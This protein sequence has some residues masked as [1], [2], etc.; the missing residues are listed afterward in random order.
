[1]MT[2]EKALVLAQQEA[3]DI[4]LSAQKESDLDA[5]LR[6]D[7]HYDLSVLKTYMEKSRETDDHLH[8]KANLMM[9]S[10]LLTNHIRKMF[11]YEKILNVEQLENFKQIVDVFQPFLDGNVKIYNKDDKKQKSDA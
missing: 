1:M 11:I 8:V 3:F 4:Y 7:L 6:T 9:G 2:H 10:V 5:Y